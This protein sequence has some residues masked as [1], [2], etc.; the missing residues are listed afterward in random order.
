METE[1]LV[2]W[3]AGIPATQ[4]SKRVV[5]GRMIEV[6]GQKLKTW[7]QLVTLV[8]HNYRTRHGGETLSGPVT[9]VLSFRLPKPRTNTTPHPIGRNTGDIDKLTRAVFD[10]LTD[11]QI[12]GD[13]SQ[14][15]NTHASKLWATHAHEAGVRISI[16]QA[17]A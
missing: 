2:L 9:A 16:R 5:R 7:R 15:V 12:W 13:D 3:V 1:P 10:A 6:S 11:A 14:V 4:G 17:I 8:A